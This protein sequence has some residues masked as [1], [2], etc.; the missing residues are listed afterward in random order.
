MSGHDE[1]NRVPWKASLLVL[2]VLAVTI[3]VA[4]FFL[5]NELRGCFGGCGAN[6]CGVC[7]SVSNAPG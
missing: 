5:R 2:A 6:G 3:V 1:T 4:L 7:S